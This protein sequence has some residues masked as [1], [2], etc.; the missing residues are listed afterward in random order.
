MQEHL[1]LQSYQI[2]NMLK[3]AN[4]ELVLGQTHAVPVNIHL[5]KNL[6]KIKLLHLKDLHNPYDRY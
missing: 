4:L 3:F 5:M 1:V 2:L 6:I